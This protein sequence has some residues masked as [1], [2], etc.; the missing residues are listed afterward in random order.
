ARGLAPHDLK[1]AYHSLVDPRLN[2]EQSLEMAIQLSH[3][4]RNES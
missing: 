3:Q 1:T 2:Y 4:F